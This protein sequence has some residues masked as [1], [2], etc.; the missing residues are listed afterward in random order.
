MQAF[1]IARLL[2]LFIHVR[3]FAVALGCVLREDAKLLS[4]R[5]LDA[6]SLRSTARL[7]RFALA[8]LWASG[9]ALIVLDTGGELARLADNPKL[10]AKLTVVCLLTLNGVALHWIAFPA[11]CGE[12]RRGRYSI[13]IAAVLG[14][15]SAASWMSATLL[16][17]VRAQAKGF[18]YSDFMVAYAG[19]GAIAIAFALLFVRPCIARK[20]RIDLRWLERDAH[21]R[22]GED[23]PRML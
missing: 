5:A 15:I 21:V 3:A 14:A 7:V 12:V 20:L 11:L 19:I 6:S 13:A 4:P 9:T 16:G 10:L 23:V 8:V 2:L 1:A 18:D 22:P 17:I